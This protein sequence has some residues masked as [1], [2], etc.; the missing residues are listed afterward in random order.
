M[1]PASGPG[2]VR[3]AELVASL[4]L[5]ID[6]GFSQPME[7]VLRQCLIALRLADRVGVD[8]ETRASIYYTAMLI[9][10]GCHSDAHE[11]AKWFGDDLAL[12]ADKYAY[13]LKGLRSTAAMLSKV[14][15]GAD[16]PTGRL[17]TGFEFATRGYRD[18]NNMVEHHASLTRALGEQL[19]L[20]AQTVAAMGASYEQWDGRG[21]PGD[22]KGEEVPLA[23]RLA[24]MAEFLEVVHRV[25]GTDAACD[26]VRRQRGKQLD[27]TLADEFLAAADV[28]LSELDSDSWAAVIEAEPS[29]GVVLDDEGYDRAL[30]AAEM[31]FRHEHALQK[32]QL[33]GRHVRCSSTGSTFSLFPGMIY[34]PCQRSVSANAVTFLI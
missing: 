22:L 12:K 26:F 11:Q 18:L 1:E 21:W 13:G 17:R 8:E 19:G 5:G 24:A 20:P 6:L 3:L 28:L 16:S 23:S 33:Q 27:P 32:G 29:L 30:T 14:G 15:S 31:D 10:V 9:N 4:S 34:M 25:Q 2:G 7:H